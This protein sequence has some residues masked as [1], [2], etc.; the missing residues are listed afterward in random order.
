MSHE[1]VPLLFPGL[2]IPVLMAC[3]SESYFGQELEPFLDKLA[4][5]FHSSAYGQS[6]QCRPDTASSDPQADGL[7]PYSHCSH[8]C[9]LRRMDDEPL[10]WSIL[11]L[12]CYSLFWGRVPRIST[13]GYQVGMGA[14]MKYA[15]YEAV[16]SRMKTRNSSHCL[17]I[18]ASNICVG[19]LNN[20][21]TSHGYRPQA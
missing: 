9:W 4:K 20:C 13:E 16:H 6:V 15:P 19:M 21:S 11:C 8:C 12:D 5:F 3:S 10:I 2:Y 14:L 7:I 1:W 18:E 17:P